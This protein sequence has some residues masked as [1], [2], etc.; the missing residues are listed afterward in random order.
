MILRLAPQPPEGRPLR[1]LLVGAHADD[2]EIG[3]GG[4]VIRLLQEHP[5][6]E[7]RYAVFSADPVRAAEARAAAAELTQGAARVTVD[8]FSFRDSFFPWTETEQL[9]ETFAGLRQGFEPDIIFTHRREDLH[10]D[11]ALL[12]QLT[13]TT[14][15]NHLVL[16][17]EIPKYEGDLGGCNVFVPL[18]EVQARRKVELVLRHFPSQ[19]SKPWFRGATFEA[20][21][22]LRGV[23]SNAAEGWAEAF[24]ARK[25]L[26]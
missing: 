26:L 20:L 25:L 24:H 4:A 19:T 7:V 3:C 22:R 1:L 2:I 12:G 18:T 23:E 17:Y 10:Q 15:R 21:M 5:D 14:F 8:V 6:A 16:E 13:W 9:K 11:H